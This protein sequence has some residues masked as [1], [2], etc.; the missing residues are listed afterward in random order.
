[1][2]LP[3][4][5]SLA[6]RRSS[7]WLP[8]ILAA[9]RSFGRTNWHFAYSIGPIRV[10]LPAATGAPVRFRRLPDDAIGRAV[11]A[12][13]V[14]E[15]CK[16]L[17]SQ[18]AA[19]YLHR[20]RSEPSIMDDFTD[21]E[22]HGFMSWEHVRRLAYQGFSIA[23]HTVSHPILTGSSSA[24]VDQELRQ[25]KS[26]IEAE[27]GSECSCFVYPNGC[28]QSYSGK[29]MRQCERAGYRV[30]LT[31]TNQFPALGGSPF[32]LS[33]IYVPGQVPDASFEFR[34]SNVYGMFR[35]FLGSR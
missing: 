26:R 9:S 4:C 28:G 17:S 27:T 19:E 21:P 32:A 7:A 5:N 31:L 15:Q 35:R 29:V 14:R 2:L 33:R 1:M 30:A 25:S 24:D 12:N 3:S 22:L 11:A 18:T 13:Q 34:T 16:R 23:S 6:S 20:L 8:D 10:L